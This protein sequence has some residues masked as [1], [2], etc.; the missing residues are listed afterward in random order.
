MP[1]KAS[2]LPHCPAGTRRQ[3]VE[4]DAALRINPAMHP[5]TLGPPRNEGSDP[6][7][8]QP[9]KK[10][11]VTITSV[12]SETSILSSD[13]ARTGDFAAKSPATGSSRSRR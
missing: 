10:I 8:K 3:L 13:G 12:A 4:L 5:T 6:C 1:V 11:L 7:I 9:S 2:H